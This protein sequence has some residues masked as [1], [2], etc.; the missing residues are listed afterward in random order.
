MSLKY[1]DG[2]VLA[3][4]ARIDER[5]VYLP[6]DF[7]V[8]DAVF[9]NDLLVM[10]GCSLWHFGVLASSVHRAWIRVLAKHEDGNSQSY[11]KEAADGC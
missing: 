5:F 2:G 4:P 8:P 10:R 11:R 7:V 1:I 9:G 6:V 3:M